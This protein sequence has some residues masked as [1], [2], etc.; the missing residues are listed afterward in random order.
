MANVQADTSPADLSCVPR[1]PSKQLLLTAQA[2]VVPPA[3]VASRAGSATPRMGACTGRGSGSCSD[4]RGLAPVRS[5]L[6]SFWVAGSRSGAVCLLS[7][8]SSG[9]LLEKRLSQRREAFAVPRACGF[10]HGTSAQVTCGCRA[11]C[12]VSVWGPVCAHQV[13]VQK[14]QSQCSVGPPETRLSCLLGSL[15]HEPLTVPSPA[16]EAELGPEAT[17]S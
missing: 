15:S 8:P 7:A 12:P 3:G 10:R 11:R 6:G 13:G 9:K 2:A 16:Q 4:R 17:F 5:V 1:G 14:P